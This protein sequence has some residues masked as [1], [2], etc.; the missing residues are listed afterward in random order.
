[1]VYSGSTLTAYMN[2]QV[3]GSSSG[4]RQAPYEY[5]NGLY[6]GIGNGDFATNLGD[7]SFSTIKFGQLEIWNGAIS[8]DVVLQNYNDNVGI[9]VC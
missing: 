6:Y 7:G 3:V 1:M 9:W 5:S 8:S 2:G 4:T